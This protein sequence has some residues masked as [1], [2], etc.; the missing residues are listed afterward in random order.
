MRL[1]RKKQ[2]NIPGRRLAPDGTTIKSDLSGGFRRNQTLV[3]AASPGINSPRSQT[4][5]LTIKRR[6]VASVLLA[7]I[8]SSAI[9]FI[10]VNQFTASASVSVVNS[11]V[12]KP[13]DLSG[14]EKAIQDYLDT[15][16]AGRLAFLLDSKAL[17]A[18]VIDKMPEVASVVQ[19]NAVGI[20]KTR[21]SVELRRPVAGWVI[22]NK[23]YYVDSAGASFENNYFDEPTVQI[24]DESGA[25]VQSGAAVVSKRFLGFVGRVV[26]LAKDRGYTVTQAIIPAGTTRELK[27][28]IQ[29]GDHLISLS[30][31][32]AVGEQIEDMDRAVKYFDSQGKK[33]AYIDVRV[34]GKA[35]YR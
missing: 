8:T 32:R 26:A 20:G 2:S 14:Y 13:I 11:S 25:A 27:I 22:N 15:N 16:P 12:L 17:D 9:L 3:N 28:R 10:L 29:E 34:S 1:F 18:Y 30:I 24:L 4:H 33:P 5:H 31:D 7:V 35:F 6:K 21:F 23:Q 19:K